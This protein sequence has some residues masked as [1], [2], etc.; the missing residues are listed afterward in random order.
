V[1]FVFPDHVGFTGYGKT[2]GMCFDKTF[3]IRARLVGRG[4]SPDCHKCRKNNLDFTGCGKTCG[5]CFKK[6]LCIRARLQSCRKCCKSNRAF[7]P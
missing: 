6:A 7:R 3:C 2:R 5:M 1:L 4:F